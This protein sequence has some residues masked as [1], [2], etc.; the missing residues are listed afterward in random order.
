MSEALLCGECPWFGPCHIGEDVADEDCWNWR[1][2]HGLELVRPAPPPEPVAVPKAPRPKRVRKQKPVRE[3]LAA[4]KAAMTARG[5]R[6]STISRNCSSLRHISREAL[7]DLSLD[8][9][10][11]DPARRYMA[12][13][14]RL[15]RELLLGVPRLPVT[16]PEYRAKA[17]ATKRR[18]LTE[19]CGNREPP[20]P[21]PVLAT[22]P[23]LWEYA[24]RLLASGMAP[25]GV[26]ESIWYISQIPEDVL[27]GTESAEALAV[28]LAPGNSEY[29]HKRN[30]T[31]IRRYRK[32]MEATAAAIDSGSYFG[33]A[34]VAVLETSTTPE[35]AWDE[36]RKAFPDSPRGIAA[37]LKA[38][39]RHRPRAVEV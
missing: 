18:Q 37:V 19:R 27:T 16:A 9:E 15:Y 7:E 1:R 34:E 24:E 35:I 11:L 21:L 38:W 31:C 14:V 26:K 33:P 12:Q 23:D 17:E 32:V 22:R 3:D 30:A 39:G 36:Y 28:R 4:M 2:D 6:P 25:T 10:T 20:V 13:I 5:Y 8:A 29:S